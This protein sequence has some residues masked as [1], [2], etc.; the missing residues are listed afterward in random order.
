MKAENLVGHIFLF[1]KKIT[2][3]KKNEPD[4]IIKNFSSFV[5]Q[6]IET[7]NE[8]FLNGDI[9]LIEYIIS[10][11]T[12][13]NITNINDLEK[14]SIKINAE[15]GLLNQFGQKLPKLEELRLNGSNIISV[16]NIGTDFRNLRI[17]QV[18]NCNLKDLSGNNL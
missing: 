2:Q 4:Q 11:F 10:K 3:I 1:L 17:L 6:I 9:N 14:L 7:Q 18:N 5:K 12:N 8:N 15:F 16:S 13:V